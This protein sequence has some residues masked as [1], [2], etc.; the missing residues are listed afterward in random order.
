VGYACEGTA[1]VG[2]GVAV[3]FEDC[4]AGEGG[5]GG[6]GLCGGGGGGAGEDTDGVFAV[7]CEGLGVGLVGGSVW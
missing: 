6:E 1:E 4:Y 3:A 5:E 7:G 2:L